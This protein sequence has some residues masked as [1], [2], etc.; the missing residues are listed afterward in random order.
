MENNY[1]KFNK[2]IDC[3]ECKCNSCGWNPDVARERIKAWE[4]KRRMENKKD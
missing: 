1:C 2:R 3:M 4:I